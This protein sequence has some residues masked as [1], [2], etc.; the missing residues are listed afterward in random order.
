VTKV[1]L[2]EAKG[3]VDEIVAKRLQA[4]IDAMESVL[5]TSQ[6]QKFDVDFN[7]ESVTENDDEGGMDAGD[8]EA[9]L[10]DH[11]KSDSAPS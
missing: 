7:D 9:L 5:N 1:Y 3:T 10:A 8:I 4:K 11:L 6:I 2:L